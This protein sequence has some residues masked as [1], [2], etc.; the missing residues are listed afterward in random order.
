MQIVYARRFSASVVLTIAAVL[1]FNQICFAQSRPQKVETRRGDQKKNDR[2]VPR[3]EEELRQETE[4]VKQ[5]EEEKNAIVDDEV[6]KIKTNIVNVDAVVYNKKTGQIISGLKKE[7]FAVFE[8]GVKQDIANFAMPE[9]PITVSLVV[10]FSKWSEIFGSY[11][12]RG[13]EMGTAEVVRPVAYF[14][15]KFIKAPDDYASVIAFDIRP[16]PI[17][18]F[19]NDPNRLRQT[20]DLLLRNSPAFR[21]NNIY[22][23]LKFALVG[24]RGDSVV[25]ENSKER[26]SIYGGMVAV[27]SKRRAIILVTSGIDTFS[28]INYGEARKIIQEAGVPIYVIGTGNLF[29]K[30]Y[31]D[32]LSAEGSITGMPGRLDF[33]QAANAMGTF[34][35][36]SGGQFFP[37]TFPG[38][39]PSVL[40]SINGLLRSQYSIAFDAGEQKREPGKKNKLQV[41]VDLNGDGIYEEK[42][43][44]IQHRPFYTTPK[45]APTQKN[46]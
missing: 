41:K 10:E 15:S 34:A 6:L 31:E 2:P 12:S 46:K 25:L 21:E 45:D 4:R 26:T 16:T 33:M 43:L 17:T 5:E 35:K 7:N 1:F 3:T 32:R 11:G 30:L 42:D 22:D 29:Y 44:V 19:T 36:E 39:L 37:V 18:D 27:Q 24:G 20:V 14:L 23:A 40:G 8:N 38:E 9:A 28:K 13:Q